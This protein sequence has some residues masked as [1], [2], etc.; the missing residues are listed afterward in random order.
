MGLR[1]HWK[2][3]EEEKSLSRVQLFVTRWTV[4][5]QAPRSMG[6]SRNEYWSGLPF[7]PSGDLP[8][9]GIE[10][11]SPT[12]QVDSLSSEPS[13]K[14]FYMG[15]GHFGLR[16]IIMNPVELESSSINPI[17]VCMYHISGLSLS[18]TCIHTYVHSTKQMSDFRASPQ[19]Y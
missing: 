12:L 18:H 1:K 5:H 13:G 7:P 9:P 3:E 10:S 6:F 11:S 14:L 16:S 4:A 2:K 17:F 19:M 8:N 15:T